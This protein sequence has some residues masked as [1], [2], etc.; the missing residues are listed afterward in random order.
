[1]Q[2]LRWKRH[3]GI[4]KASVGMFEE[5]HFKQKIGIAT[6]PSAT[7]EELIVF[8]NSSE[9]NDKK[10]IDEVQELTIEALEA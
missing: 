4:I 8:S 10:R 1:V 2:H 3:L 7:M 9:E 5:R 6:G